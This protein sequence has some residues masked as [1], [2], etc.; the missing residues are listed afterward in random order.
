MAKELKAGDKVSWDT[1]QG[2]THGKIVK[3]QMMPTRIK[4]HKVAASKDNPQY[5]G[6]EMSLARVIME[7]PPVLAGPR[8]RRDGG[9]T[10]PLR[11][12]GCARRK[13]GFG[14]VARL[15]RHAGESRRPEAPPSRTV[16]GS[17]LPP[18]RAGEVST[19]PRDTAR[20]PAFPP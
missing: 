8:G 1:S 7:K 10:G 17:R 19:S 14:V 6:T 9:W 16:A 20:F 4:G 3:R 12:G 11:C 18:G 13:S 15:L 5:I 2:K